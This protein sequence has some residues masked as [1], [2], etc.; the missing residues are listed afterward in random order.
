MLELQPICVQMIGWKSS[1]DSCKLVKGFKVVFLH[2]GFDP[3]LQF[4]PVIK[5]IFSDFLKIFYRGH[6]PSAGYHGL[7]R[8]KVD[9]IP[10]FDGF[11]TSRRQ[12]SR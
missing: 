9:V 11:S 1:G 4:V 10:G 3:F 8:L 6:I 7:S 2:K 12:K 5:N